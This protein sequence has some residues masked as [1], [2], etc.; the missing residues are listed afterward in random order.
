MTEK[1]DVIVIGGGITGLSAAFDIATHAAGRSLLL[2]EAA[3]RAGGIV[4]A[5]HDRGY[6]VDL[7]PHGFVDNGT[8]V[9]WLIDDLRLEKELVP[10]TV[11]ARRIYMLRH[12]RLFR[13]PATGRQL[14]TTPLLSMRGKL[15][16]MGEVLVPP[17]QDEE[18]AIAFVAR[19]FGQEVADT[20]A[21]PAVRGVIGG[22]ADTF[23]VEGEF[24]M[25]KYL[26]RRY[27]S[28]LIGAVRAQIQRRKTDPMATRLPSFK[29]FG[30]RL[31]TFRG[32]GMQRLI[33]SLT[34][35]LGD[36]IKLN[37]AVERLERD[38]KGGWSVSVA[39]GRQFHAAQVVLALPTDPTA[40]LL[41]PLLPAAAKELDAL[42]HP[43]IRVIALGYRRED[44]GL[45][46]PGIG[47]IAEP[48]SA[49]NVLGAIHASS[50]FPEQAPA[51]TV[52][53]RTLAGGRSDA[54]ILTTTHE[55]AVSLIH[56]DLAKAFRLRAEPVFSF[57][58]VWRRPIPVYPVGHRSRMDAVMADAQQ[59]GGLHLTGNSFYGV[60]VNDCVRDARRVADAVLGR[61]D[62]VDPVWRPY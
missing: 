1:Y 53:I 5:H 57:D 58:H 10:A 54:P 4:G 18:S 61:T 55:R 27:G 52:M 20:F 23:S 3:P 33:D 40:D 45:V 15:R 51:G 42:P 56:H 21:V 60:G 34:A 41:R 6:T 38:P 43:D 2:L 17:R 28:V 29:E 9:R 14:L 22:D 59:L 49:S 11:Q 39:G 12:D 30:M 62:R 25:I 44:V 31:K 24:P 46:P 50:I 19:R 16:L 36:R 7:G 35:A 47:F 32:N 13:V 8:D 48:D 26:E 37:S